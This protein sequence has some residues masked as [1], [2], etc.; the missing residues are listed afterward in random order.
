MW[1]SLPLASFDQ[2]VCAQEVECGAWHTWAISGLGP[3][4]FCWGLWAETVYIMTSVSLLM[5][6]GG[7]E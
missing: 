1:L 3:A 2:E 6:G 4:F 5:I 7:E